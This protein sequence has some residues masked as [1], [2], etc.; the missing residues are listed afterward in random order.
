MTKIIKR[1]NYLIINKIS[2]IL[3]DYPSYNFV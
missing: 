1:Y 3:Y 2:I